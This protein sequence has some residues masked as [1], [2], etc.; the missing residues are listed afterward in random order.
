MKNLIF[1]LLFLGCTSNQESND[2][3]ILFTSRLCG[4]CHA[5]KAIISQL[6]VD[7]IISEDDPILAQRYNIIRVP[8]LIIKENGKEVKRVIGL[9]TPETYRKL[10]CIN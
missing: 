6:D 1:I 3:P 10:L 8:T 4:P 9:Q 2:T 7:I 5:A